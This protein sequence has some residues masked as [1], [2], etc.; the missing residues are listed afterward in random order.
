MS[1]NVDTCKPKN[2][3]VKTKVVCTIGPTSCSLSVIKELINNGMCL[4]R[5][6]K[7]HS[8]DEVYNLNSN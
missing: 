4:V 6:N 7:L 3:I 1:E 5:L 8:D 2:R